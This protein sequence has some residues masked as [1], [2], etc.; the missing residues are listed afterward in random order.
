MR[1]KFAALVTNNT[2]TNTKN[3]SWKSACDTVIE[4]QFGNGTV[5][6]NLENISMVVNT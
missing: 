5:N 1:Y 6:N 3:T 4:S 2:V